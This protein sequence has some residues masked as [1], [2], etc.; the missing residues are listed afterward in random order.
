MTYALIIQAPDGPFL[1]ACRTHLVDWTQAHRSTRY[2]HPSAARRSWLA[3][4]RK[5]VV[6][7]AH[8][9]R[10]RDLPAVLAGK[11]PLPKALS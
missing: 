9:V 10:H 4:Q 11:M 2:P 7:S 1:A 3:F 6:T 8:L 5:Y